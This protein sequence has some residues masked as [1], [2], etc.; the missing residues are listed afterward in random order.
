MFKR[1]RTGSLLP[2][3]INRVPRFL[4]YEAL[5][6][7]F[8]L[9]NSLDGIANEQSKRA[10]NVSVRSYVETGFVDRLIAVL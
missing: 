5:L 6:R 7:D 3:R 1:L 4:R 2:R 9:W 8:V 10:G